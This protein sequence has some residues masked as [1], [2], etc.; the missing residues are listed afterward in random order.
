MAWPGLTTSPCN[1]ARVSTMPVI[2]RANFGV[3]QLHPRFF[4]LRAGGLDLF[5][6]GLDRAPGGF[7]SGPRLIVSL[8]RLD[9][10]GVKPCDALEIQPRVFQIG[11]APARGRRRIAAGCWC[12]TPCWPAVPAAE[13]CASNSPLVTVSPFLDEKLLQPALDFRTHND[14]IRR[15]DA[16]QDEFAALAR[17]GVI[18]APGNDGKTQN[19]KGNFALFHNDGKFG[20]TNRPWRMKSST[21]CLRRFKL[22]RCK[23]PQSPSIAARRGGEIKHNQPDHGHGGVKTVRLAQFAVPHSPLQQFAQ[24]LRPRHEVLMHQPF[25]SLP[26]SIMNC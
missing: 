20:S 5:L 11:L 16:G 15:H 13:S 9:V 7:V 18:N 4:L 21:S 22:R 12:K 2:G 24:R 14:F 23:G 10:V 8:H 17:A 6:D 1:A 25:R 26:P 19:H 3:A